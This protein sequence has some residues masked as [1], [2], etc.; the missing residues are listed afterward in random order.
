MLLGRKPALKVTA[1]DISQKAVE[2]TKEK[3]RA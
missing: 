1:L 2:L 3:R